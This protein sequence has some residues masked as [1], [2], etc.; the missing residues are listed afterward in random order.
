M[1][2]QTSNQSSDHTCRK[3]WLRTKLRHLVPIGTEGK[4]NFDEFIDNI[5]GCDVPVFELVLSVQ[6][7]LGDSDPTGG[8]TSVCIFLSVPFWQWR[9]LNHLVT[10]LGEQLIAILRVASAP[11]GD[12]VD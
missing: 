7:L 8:L 3:G 9:K 12:G 11:R 1:T 2:S 10:T 4:Q 6:M 5:G